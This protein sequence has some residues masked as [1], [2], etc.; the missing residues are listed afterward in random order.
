MAL[1]FDN[2]DIIFNIKNSFMMRIEGYTNG[3]KRQYR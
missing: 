1:F 3:K 2:N